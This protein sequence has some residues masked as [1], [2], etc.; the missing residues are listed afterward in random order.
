MV[1]LHGATGEVAWHYQMVH[2]DIWDYDTPAQPTLMD[3]EVNGETVPVVVQV[4][5]MGLTFVLHRDTGIPVYP[6]E[7]RPVPQN[8]V[9]GEYLSPTQPF[10]THFPNL[11]PPISADDAWGLMIWDEMMCANTLNQLR[12]DGIYTPPPWR[13]LSFTQVMAAETIG[14]RLP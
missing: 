6:V 11:M 5:K 9:I 8:P 2:H 4:T 10:P 13:A 12:N 3:L 7:E 14:V 1:A